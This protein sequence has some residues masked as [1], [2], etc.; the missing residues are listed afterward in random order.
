MRP[1]IGFKVSGTQPFLGIKLIDQNEIIGVQF[2]TRT[3]RTKTLVVFQVDDFW[4]MKFS[5]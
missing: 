3:P 1:A 5:V 2:P 4:H